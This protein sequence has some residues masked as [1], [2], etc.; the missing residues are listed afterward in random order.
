MRGEDFFI[1]VVK[2]IVND[3]DAVKVVRTIDE[4]G[5]LLTVSLNPKDAGLLIG[6]KGSVINSIRTL[7]RVIGIRSGEKI[8]IKVEEP[9]GRKYAEK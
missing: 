5:V 6:T 1:E 9:L 7:T 8:S 2:N 4:R 3:P